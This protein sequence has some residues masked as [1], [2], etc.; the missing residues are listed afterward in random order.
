MRAEINL[1]LDLVEDLYKPDNS[2]SAA[3]SKDY[4]QVISVLQLVQDAY[5]EIIQQALKA[6]MNND[7]N[8]SHD[9]LQKQ[10]QELVSTL[11]RIA[12][13]IEVI[14]TSDDAFLKM[15]IEYVYTRARLVDEL[16]MF[17]RFGLELLD[18]M[19]FDESLDE[20]IHS[21]ESVMTGKSRLYQNIMSYFD[22]H[23]S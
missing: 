22:E 8:K 17:P 23:I 20:T 2:C 15:I 3:S 10:R 9:L 19:T 4:S 6:L 16:K 21:M 12:N 7:E 13:L 1:V 5:V 18:R 14:A 11:E